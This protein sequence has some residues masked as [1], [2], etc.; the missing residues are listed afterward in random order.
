MSAQVKQLNVMS[1]MPVVL[2]ALLNHQMWV[3]ASVQVKLFIFLFSPL[4]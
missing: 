2:V 3:K 4:F 1:V